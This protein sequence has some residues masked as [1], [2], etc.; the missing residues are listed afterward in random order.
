MLLLFFTNKQPS[1]EPLVRPAT[2]SL[3]EFFLI[4]L[5]KAI[6]HRAQKNL[7][8]PK[9]IFVGKNVVQKNTPNE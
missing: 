9:K 1:W 3:C 4:R 6:R 7:N 8:P 5:A 2:N